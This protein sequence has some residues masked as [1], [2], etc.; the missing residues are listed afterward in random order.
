[1]I[2]SEPP[3]ERYVAATSGRFGCEFVTFYRNIVQK[4]FKR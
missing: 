1:M 4:S 2:N 3:Q